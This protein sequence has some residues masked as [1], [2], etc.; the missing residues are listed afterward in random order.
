[1]NSVDDNERIRQLETTCEDLRRRLSEERQVKD[2]FEDLLSALKADLQASHNERDN[3]RDE[4]VPQLRA[5]VEGLEAQSAQQQQLEY[6][7]TAMQQEVQKLKDEN[8]TLK[9]AHQMQLDMQK[10]MSRF[11]TIVEEASAVP[12]KQRAS[13]GLTRSNSLARGSV[14]GSQ[15]P[16]G[17]MSRS[18]SVKTAESRD[19]LAE[20]VKEVELQRDALHRALKSLLERQELQNRDNEKRIRQLEAERDKALTSQPKRPG[21]NKDVSALRDEINELR[22]RAVEAIEQK[23]QC[24][25]GLSGLKMDLDRAEQEISSLRALLQEKDNSMPSRDIDG[26]PSSPLPPTSESLEKSFRDLQRSYADSLERIKTLEMP[27]EDTKKAMGQLQQSLSA[28]IS[29]RDFFQTEVET[30]KSQ[31]ESLQASE[32]EH[33]TSEMSMADELRASAKSVEDLAT[34]VR[35]QMATNGSLRQ[36]LAE[37]IGRGEA[38][39]KSNASRIMHMQGKLKLLEEQLVTAQH[40]SEESISKHEEKIRELKESHNVQL[41]RMKEGLKSPRRFSSKSPL[42]PLFSSSPNTPGKTFPRI[43]RTSTG[44][45]LSI[46]AQTKIDFLSSK[47]GELEKA[48]TDADREMEEVVGRMNIAQIEVME[49]QNE[50]E[51]AVRET[52]RLQR[53]IEEERLRGFENRWR[54]L[55]AGGQGGQ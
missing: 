3:L 12:P 1:M 39:Q 17:R 7:Q 27:D 18:N 47:V 10:Q 30:Y 20:R 2:N 26:V 11:N 38:E 42:T 44:P 33:I 34:Q 15:L 6:E 48:L 14:I 43:S 49:L 24:E 5:R 9:N 13:A 52:R 36:R 35:Q 40:Q 54:S 25:R 55:S 46:S 53:I 51:E 19:A 29:E 28:A 32:K 45:A 31:V 41:Q 4:I 21:F 23:E 8:M 50:R 16:S 22:R 37:A